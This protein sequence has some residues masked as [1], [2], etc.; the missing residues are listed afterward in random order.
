M[1]KIKEKILFA[2]DQAVHWILVVYY[3]LE[4]HFNEYV[5]PKMRKMSAKCWV[6]TVALITLGYVLAKMF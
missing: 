3:W 1:E 4:K 6:G 2:I 5:V